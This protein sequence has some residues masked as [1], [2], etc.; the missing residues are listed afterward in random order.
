MIGKTNFVKFVVIRSAVD[1][2]FDGGENYWDLVEPT[3]TPTLAH[4]IGKAGISTT[5]YAAFNGLI[6]TEELTDRTQ[7]VNN[8]QTIYFVHRGLLDL[9]PELITENWSISSSRKGV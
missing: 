2:S 5:T 1:L 8:K 9:R 4:V 3:E 7:T 6:L